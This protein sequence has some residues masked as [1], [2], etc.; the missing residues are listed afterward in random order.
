MS[1]QHE[2]EYEPQPRQWDR[3]NAAVRIW[4][5][6]GNPGGI[7]NAIVTACRQMRDENRSVIAMCQDPAVR[8]MVYTLAN[9]CGLEQM[10]AND[11]ADWQH[12]CRVGK[13]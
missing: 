1:E 11:L 8:L 3:H 9:V 13:T 7:A 4:D 6:A 2:H 12:A 10:S 5:G